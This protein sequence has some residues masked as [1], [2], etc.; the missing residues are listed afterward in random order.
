M[1]LDRDGVM[2]V[3]LADGRAVT[4][5]Q[6]AAQFA[7]TSM[8]ERSI[9]LPHSAHLHLRTTRGDDVLLELPLGGDQAVASSVWCKRRGGRW[10]RD[11]STPRL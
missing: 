10:L 7:P 6:R 8:V 9:Y 2:S 3:V 5:D 1:S 4:A 11:H